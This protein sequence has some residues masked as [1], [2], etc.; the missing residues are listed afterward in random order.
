[1]KVRS[2]QQARQGNVINGVPQ[3]N[4]IES[5]GAEDRRQVSGRQVLWL[6]GMSWK[7]GWR[8]GA[9]IR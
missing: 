3:T 2:I 9:T 7:V 6:R 5:G 4:R 8:L 1:M